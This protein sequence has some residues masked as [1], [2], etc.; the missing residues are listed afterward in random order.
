M[1]VIFKERA[2]KVQLFS[3]PRKGRGAFLVQWVAKSH[4]VV[5][6][7]G[8]ATEDDEAFHDV[9]QL[10]DVACPLVLLQSLDGI[11]LEGGG[12]LAHVLRERIYETLHQE[13]NVVF[14]LAQGRHL[15]DDDA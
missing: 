6:G 9:V 5:M 15:D 4:H 3:L 11:R 10:A 1:I 8:V 7:D 12:D 13:R 2:A 14:A